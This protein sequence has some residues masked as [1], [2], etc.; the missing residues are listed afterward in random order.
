MDA[1]RRHR[2]RDVLD[3]ERAGERQAWK[4][5]YWYELPRRW[6]WW[7]TGF[8]STMCPAAGNASS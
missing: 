1:G 5:R 2:A 6:L 3:L 4:N 7:T 8:V